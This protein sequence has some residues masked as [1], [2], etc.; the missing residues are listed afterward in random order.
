MQDPDLKLYIYVTN[1]AVEGT[2]SQNFDR[3]LSSFYKK[4]RKNILKRLI[5]SYPFF[6]IK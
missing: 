5:K 2:V 1:I 3:G 4:S 6:N